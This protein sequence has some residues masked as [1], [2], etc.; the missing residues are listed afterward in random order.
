MLT[1]AQDTTLLRSA[2][3]RTWRALRD[4]ESESGGEDR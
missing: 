3:T 1:V 2:L 4:A